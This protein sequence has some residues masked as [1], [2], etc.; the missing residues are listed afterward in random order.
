MK[1]A[2]KVI[3]KILKWICLVIVTLVVTGILSIG[4]F[5]LTRLIIK[6]IA[7]REGTDTSTSA[8][9]DNAAA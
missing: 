7:K 6:T 2:L 1:K 5:F 8:V 4:S 3:L 9:E